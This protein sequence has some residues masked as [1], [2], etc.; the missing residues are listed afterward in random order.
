MTINIT[1]QNGIQAINIPDDMKI[2]DDKVYLKK[3]GNSIHVIPYHSAGQ[4]LIDS[5]TSFTNDFMET[6]NQPNE[7]NRESFE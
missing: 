3:I 2:N 1:K 6:R 7:Q 5:T 4:N